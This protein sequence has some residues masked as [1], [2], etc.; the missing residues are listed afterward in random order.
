MRRGQTREK[1]K[2]PGDA[3]ALAHASCLHGDMACPLGASVPQLCARHSD[4]PPGVLW[5]N[6]TT[7]ST[8]PAAVGKVL[9][10]RDMLMRLVGR[11]YG[12]F[13]EQDFSTW[14]ALWDSGEINELCDC[15]GI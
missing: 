10:R 4:H 11:G 13:G 7:G 12:D 2:A 15:D 6:A 8:L 1:R 9:Q 5:L 3:A 14:E